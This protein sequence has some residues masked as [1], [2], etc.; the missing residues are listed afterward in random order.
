MARTV[1]VHH[2]PAEGPLLSSGADAL[3]LIYGDDLGEAEWIA[4][5]AGRLDPA[6]FALASGVAG[7]FVQ[8]FAY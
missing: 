2:V 3:R 6:F 8:K 4:V 7:E 5:P 1:D